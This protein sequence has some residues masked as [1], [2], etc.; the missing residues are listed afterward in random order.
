LL[1]YKYQ[2][3]PQ[4]SFGIP[5]FKTF[6]TPSSKPFS[7]SAV[8]M[9]DRDGPKYVIDRIFGG[10][11]SYDDIVGPGAPES[12]TPHERV[13]PAI[14]MNYLPPS[15]QIENAVKEG[16]D[17]IAHELLVLTFDSWMHPRLSWPRFI[18]DS[19]ARR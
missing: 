18:S 5:S 7:I 8:K 4:T 17:I 11:A 6:I 12:S 16:M 1:Q 19:I 14:P 10:T 9:S 2:A 15:P 13:W 3:S